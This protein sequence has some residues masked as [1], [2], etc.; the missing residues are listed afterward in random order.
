MVNNEKMNNQVNDSS[1]AQV[2]KKN[3]NKTIGIV[4]LVIGLLLLGFGSYK[5]FI[6]KNDTNVN[7]KDNSVKDNNEQ[8]QENNISN[9]QNNLNNDSNN[10]N[11]TNIEC[12]YYPSNENTPSETFG[13]ECDK[14]NPRLLYDKYKLP[15]NH[16]IEK[17]V[18][19]NDKL[20][21]LVMSNNHDDFSNE[22]YHEY[23]YSLE[24]NEI[25]YVN[26][27]YKRI[28]GVYTIDN[29]TKVIMYNEVE[30]AEKFDFKTIDLTNNI[31]DKE[32]QIN[33]E[34]F[35]NPIIVSKNNKYY[36]ALTLTS[37]YTD[38]LILNT[39]FN[40]IDIGLAYHPYDLLDNGNIK[41]YVGSNVYKIYDEK[42]NMISEGKN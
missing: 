7:K 29:K 3:N 12:N 34:S 18:L 33:V 17:M 9:N 5:L 40:K 32:V 39:D 22:K 16:T 25:Y 2:E 37:E 19:I 24:N 26:D 28:A 14:Y 42:G 21:Y 36:I 20:A 27:S 1:N 10:Y 41:I 23:L 11:L 31:V 6:E 13:V 8:E 35:T 4:I 38:Q 30:Y 15:S